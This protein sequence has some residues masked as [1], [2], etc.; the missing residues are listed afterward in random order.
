[1]V[2]MSSMIQSPIQALVRPAMWLPVLRKFHSYSETWKID[3][4]LDNFMTSVLAA[5]SVL[6][7]MDTAGTYYDV[8][9]V[10]SKDGFVRIFVLT[11]AEWLD[12]IEIKTTGNN[13]EI[14]FWVPFLDFGLNKTRLQKLREAMPQGILCT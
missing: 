5:V 12:V 11:W 10:D 4:S 9:K 1:M 7:E 13:V 6:I 3:A 8:H 2:S 14:F